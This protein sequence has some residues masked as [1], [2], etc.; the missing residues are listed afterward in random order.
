VKHQSTKVS[1]LRHSHCLSLL[2]CGQFDGEELSF[3]A[4]WT[5]V[6]H[7]QEKIIWHARLLSVELVKHKVEKKIQKQSH[8]NFVLR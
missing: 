7:V 4:D 8:Q 6:D 1:F 3:V 2:V 5:S